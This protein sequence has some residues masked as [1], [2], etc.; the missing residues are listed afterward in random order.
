MD[1]M[2]I[3]GLIL[4]IGAILLG[5]ILDGGHTESLVIFTAFLIVFGGTLGAVM[6]E[7]SAGVFIQ[8]IKRMRWMLTPPAIDSK[9]TIAKIV[10][11][12]QT[13]RKEGLLSLQNIADSEPDEFSRTGLQMLADGS[14][15]ESIR[16]ALE[17]EISMTEHKDMLAAKVFESFG[18]YAPTI[19]IIGAV[20]GLIHV[21][22][23]LS[24]P[25]TLGSGIA[26]AFV[27]TI[28][29]VGMANLIFLPMAK[30]LKTIIRAQ[31]HHRE[32]IVD[33]VVLIAEGE[34]HREI[35]RILQGY[36]RYE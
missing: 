3:L 17:I 7:T 6:V 23:N 15:P 34:S 30:K 32:M 13:A 5:N 10:K 9:G 12:S 33:G 18:G 22:N 8:S 21:M 35:E 36:L 27:A 31:S 11:W 4:G 2:T 28:Y 1:I 14:E 24:D 19:G 25:A 16:S 20:L 26:V 29:G